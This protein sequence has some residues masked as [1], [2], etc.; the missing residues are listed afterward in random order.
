MSRCQRSRSPC[1]APLLAGSAHADAS[2][3]KCSTLVEDECSEMVRQKL[4]CLLRLAP[5]E[6]KNH[7]FLNGNS[8]HVE[9][10]SSF[11]E[12]SRERLQ[13]RM[14]F[15]VAVHPTG[16][17]VRVEE[18]PL[19]GM[20]PIRHSILLVSRRSELRGDGFAV[21]SPTHNAKGLVEVVVCRLCR[22]NRS[23]LERLNVRDRALGPKA[24][25]R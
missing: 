19:P 21:P 9:R 2:S 24:Q 7:Q 25:R 1:F 23:D 11:G 17:H 3:L 6:R 5:Q 12:R 15:G 8:R 20:M 16:H 18:H 14:E 4:L 10:R 22:G 13:R